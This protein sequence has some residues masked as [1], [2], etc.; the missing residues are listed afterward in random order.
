MGDYEPAPVTIGRRL[1]AI[2]VTPL[3]LGA[4][5]L[6]AL[7]AAIYVWG[8]FL[9]DGP[10]EDEDGV[11]WLPVDPPFAVV[12][13]KPHPYAGSL[14]GATEDIWRTYVVDG[15]GPPRLILESNRLPRT[16]TWTTDGRQLTTLFLTL[17][18]DGERMTGMTA[19]DTRTGQVLWERMLQ[20]PVL[21]LLSRNG[22]Q[23]VLLDRR[24]GEGS[25]TVHLVRRDGSASRLYA[26][27]RFSG[28]GP[29]SPD[30]RWLLLNSRTGTPSAEPLEYFA[31]STDGQAVRLGPSRTLP[32]WSP[33]S[34]RIALYD[35]RSPV[36][37]DL[38]SRQ[39]E[40]V[41]LGGTLPE[42]G[43]L[44]LGGFSWS[45]DCRFVAGGGAVIESSTGRLM[46]DL[47]PGVTSSVLSPD[48]R[49]VAT[50][51]DCSNRQ[52][53]GTL[54]STPMRR[55][56]VSEVSAG[57][58][59]L[60]FDC[61]DSYPYQQ[62]VDSSTLLLLSSRCIGE[63][64]CTNSILE[65]ALA[66]MPDGA[67][68]R[69]TEAG[70]QVTTFAIAPDDGRILLAGRAVRIFSSDGSLLRSMPIPDGLIVSAAAWS[71]DGRSFAYVIGPRVSS[72]LP[73][74]TP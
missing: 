28:A 23:M 58:R 56:V 50:S 19:A 70:D 51:S 10:E 55:T 12:D 46:S 4:L 60:S 54:P 35:G 40:T 32:S 22:D 48:G 45:R 31:V 11:K 8:I 29:W 73:W 64:E 20:A 1:A 59:V 24:D 27:W 6:V 2:R 36:L 68:L 34:T 5:V 57:R 42:T 9:D 25:S 74:R 26:P 67:L 37:F 65:A 41:D 43:S 62:W 66:T 38:R 17:A 39:S 63:W 44:P 7:L 18:A 61:L 15:D 49:W 47:E 16:L 3:R 53:P 33:D 30:G 13:E 21:P 72:T 52:S 14:V 71:S 69:L